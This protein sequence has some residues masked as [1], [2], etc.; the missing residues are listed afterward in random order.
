M[1]TPSKTVPPKPQT[2]RKRETHKG[3]AIKAKATGKAKEHHEIS[4]AAP[5]SFEASAKPQPLP[6]T[7]S[8][9]PVSLEAPRVRRPALEERAEQLKEEIEKTGAPSMLCRLS[10]N[11]LDYDTNEDEAY[12]AE[13]YAGALRAMPLLREAV[14]LLDAKIRRDCTHYQEYLREQ[15]EAMPTL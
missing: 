13:E 15:I 2:S 11:L 8:E 5:V 3:T 7:L 12:G 4:L 10:S 1:K 9:A 14:E 6:E